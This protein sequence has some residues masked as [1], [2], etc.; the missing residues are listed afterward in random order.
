MMGCR[1]D[2]KPNLNFGGETSDEPV[3]WKTKKEREG[4]NDNRS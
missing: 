1:K 2:K 3:P 4:L